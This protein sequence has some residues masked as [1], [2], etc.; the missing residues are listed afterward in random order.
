[1]TRRPRILIAEHAATR[2]GIRMAI[3]DE[4]E[5]CAEA[6]NAEHAIR[7]AMR[8]QPDVCLVGRE[9]PGDGLAAVRGIARAAP[10]TAVVVLAQ[11]RDVDDL[12]DAVRAGAIGYE[13]DGVNADRLLGIVRAAAAREAVIPRSMILELLMELRG[14][15][16]GGDGLTARESQVLGMLRRGH[17]TAA[18]AHRLEIA[19]VTVRR[20]ISD[21]VRKLGVEDRS[22][23]IGRDAPLLAPV[24]GRENGHRA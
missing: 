7:A 21:L 2:L 4:F 17:T 1:V 15:G 8:E 11:T 16:S 22:A 14:G 19:P 24:A 3:G 6:G 13:P 18:I 9:I 12:L 23:L 20:H 10:H 5:I